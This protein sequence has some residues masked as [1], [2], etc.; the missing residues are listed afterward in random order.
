MVFQYAYHLE[1]N[2]YMHYITHENLSDEIKIR[3]SRFISISYRADD[4]KRVK[5][6]LSQMNNRFSDANH[7]C[8]AYRICNVNQLDL[9]YNP[10][11]IEYS[12]DDGEPS[13]TAG[14]QI[15]NVMKNKSLVNRIIFV[16]RYFGGIKL[17]IKGLIDAYR[18]SAELVVSDIKLIKWVLYK[19]LVI[20]TNY[21]YHKFLEQILINHEGEI[22]NSEFSDTIIMS[23]KIP[24]KE[25][26]MFKKNINEK[27]KGTIQI[28][29]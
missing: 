13:G 12:T 8:Y 6:I 2:S 4:L 23:V 3:N 24:F 7:I 27:S 1:K 16:I 25:L 11:I 29:G 26:K 21:E 10:E 18:Q 9:F 22:V 17:G 5:S 14:R 20:K 15:L 28:I 19:D